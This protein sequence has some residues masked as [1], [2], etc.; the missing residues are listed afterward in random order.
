MTPGLIQAHLIVFTRALHRNRLSDQEFQPMVCEKIILEVCQGDDCAFRAVVES[1]TKIK[2]EKR[3]DGF[4][5]LFGVLSVLCGH[6]GIY[7]SEA[8]SA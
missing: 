1:F 8:V 7:R 5:L 3:Y 6:V 2:G 4:L